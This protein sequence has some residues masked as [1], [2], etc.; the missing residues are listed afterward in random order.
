[1]GLSS[2]TDADV[3]LYGGV[4]HKEAE[5][6]VMETR[7]LTFHDGSRTLALSSDVAKTA[8]DNALAPSGPV[9]HLLAAT[10]LTENSICATARALE[11][12]NA[13]DAQVTLLHVVEEGLSRKLTKQ[14]QRGARELLANYAD[15]L[16]SGARHDISINV[17]TGD[18]CLEIIRGSIEFGS[19]AIILGL[20]EH[21]VLHSELAATAIDVITFSDKPV[22]VVARPPP[23]PYA[24]AVIAVE[25][26]VAP[27][28]A[29]RA[30]QRLAP[31]AQAHLVRVAPTESVEAG[32]SLAHSFAAS[33]NAPDLLVDCISQIGADLLVVGL[34]RAF[35]HTYD[36]L[37]NL[38]RC[39]SDAHR[40]DL[41]FVR[42]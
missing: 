24:H 19:D 32:T 41:L 10:D 1:M 33:A 17:R 38:F 28:W 21:N 18:P 14:R 30:T 15:S 25:P 31:Q 23:G 4:G 27:G 16:C 37:S 6:L 12:A 11:R 39:I 9:G 34:E 29:L 20:E 35:Q 8:H 26:S 7:S 36:E 5:S 40:C 2:D 42:N 13:L 22:F 3:A